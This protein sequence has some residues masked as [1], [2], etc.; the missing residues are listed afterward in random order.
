M[1]WSEVAQSCLT[2]W[3]P[4]DCSPPGSSVHGILQQEY[5]SG[6]PFPSPGDLPDPGIEPRSPALQ[7]DALTSEPPGKFFALGSLKM[8]LSSWISLFNQVKV[9]WKSPV[10]SDTLWPL[11]LYTP[12]NSPGQNTRVDSHS[13]LQGIFSTQGLNPGLPHCRRILYPLSHQGSPFS[14]KGEKLTAFPCQVSGYKKLPTEQPS[15]PLL[16]V[17]T[18]SV[19]QQTNATSLRSQAWDRMLLCTSGVG[20]ATSCRPRLLSHQGLWPG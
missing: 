13:L 17:H 12:W 7:A 2:L 4:V 3:D 10:M 15:V 8:W 11:G 18:R 9:K 20:L 14:S 5:W 16:N 19:T 1:K 6:L